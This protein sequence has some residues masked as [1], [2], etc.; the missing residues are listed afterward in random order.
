MSEEIII[1]KLWALE[2]DKIYVLKIRSEAKDK[3]AQFLTNIKARFGLTIFC[4]DEDAEFVHV[5]EGYEIL[6]KEN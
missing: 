1:K 3:Y 5:P 4:I 2:K 6:K